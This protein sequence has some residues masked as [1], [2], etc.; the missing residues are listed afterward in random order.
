MEIL[1]YLTETNFSTG[2]NRPI[3]YIVMHY[4]SNNGDTAMNNA[5][6]FNSSYRGASAHYFVDETQ[7][8]RVVE[9]KNV[10]WHCGTKW[11]YKHDSCRNANS[12]GVEMCSRKDSAGNYYIMKETQANAI[13]LVQYLMELYGIPIENVI[14]HYDVT[15]KNCPAPMVDEK[16]WSDF[17]EEIEMAK[18]TKEQFKELWTEMRADLQDNDAGDWSQEARDWATN[19]GLIVGGTDGAYMWEDVLTREQMAVLLFR[20]AQMM[21]AV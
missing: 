11:A 1:D 13:E 10:S 7:V 19:S 9:D 17:K 16:V 20:F 21:G 5:V 8:V 3:D 15:G 6:Y 18:L 2:R 4:T 14:R 12:I